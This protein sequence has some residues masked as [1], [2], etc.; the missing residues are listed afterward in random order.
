MGALYDKMEQDLKLR[1]LAVTTREQYL[2]CCCNYVRYHMKSPAQ[3]GESEITSSKTRIG[4]I[5]I[6]H[7]KEHSSSVTLPVIPR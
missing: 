1:N 5:R 4:H 3:T 6:Y 2:R 7:D